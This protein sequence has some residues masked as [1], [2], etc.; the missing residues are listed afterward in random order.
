M[1]IRVAGEKLH[2]RTGILS[3]RTRTHIDIK[4]VDAAVC[5]MHHTQASTAELCAEGNFL[6]IGSEADGAA[7]STFSQRTVRI[8]IGCL[9]R[10]VEAVI[11]TAVILRVNQAAE[12]KRR[13]RYIKIEKAV[14]VLFDLGKIRNFDKK[15]LLKFGCRG[16]GFTENIFCHN[17]HFPI[18]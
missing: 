3:C 9:F 10:S 16:F 8:R 15:T 6:G 2:G 11:F 17:G 1:K 18:Y 5:E 14:F 4:S 12:D 13:I 7:G